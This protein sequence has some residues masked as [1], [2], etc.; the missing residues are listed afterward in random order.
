MKTTIK[1][2]ILSLFILASG[3]V[4]AQFLKKLKKKVTQAVENTVGDKVENSIGDLLGE[5]KNNTK[6]KRNTDIPSNPE[7]QKPPS[8]TTANKKQTQTENQIPTNSDTRF[9][10]VSIPAYNDYFEP[11][12]LLSYKGLP[13]L[14]ENDKNLVG[15]TIDIEYNNFHNL[16]RIKFYSS[17]IKRM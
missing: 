12:T 9:S 2:I 13:L 11:I 7:Y 6:K 8:N 10:T 3:T 14:G 17:F 1:T 4:N 16:L 15:N 5:E